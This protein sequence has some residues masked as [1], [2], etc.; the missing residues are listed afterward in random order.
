M[1]MEH[2]AINYVEFAARD[3][4]A[5]QAFFEQVFSWTFQSYGEDYRAFSDRKLE[6]SFYRAR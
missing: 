4:E 2:E 5:T 1:A 3:L 6:G